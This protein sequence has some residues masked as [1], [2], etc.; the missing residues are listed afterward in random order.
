MTLT[1]MRAL[2][3]LLS[4]LGLLTFVNNWTQFGFL[5]DLGI[6]DRAVA[7]LRTG[8]NPYRADAGLPFIYHPWVL[9]AFEHWDRYLPLSPSLLV[10]YLLAF[11]FAV[12]QSVQWCRAQPASI[13][14]VSPAMLPWADRLLPILAASALGGNGV[15]SVMSGN[16]TSALH[17]I[18]GG[19]ILLAA[20]ARAPRHHLAAT[21]TCLLCAFVKPYF[22]AYLL[23]ILLLNPNPWQWAMITIS[24]MCLGAF[25]ALSMSMEPAQYSLFVQAVARQTLQNN[26]LGY[27]FLNFAWAATH[28]EKLAIGA[29]L[30]LSSLLTLW[31]CMTFA[32][33]QQ[34]ALS[35]WMVP[36]LYLVLT[37]ANPRMKHY[38]LFPALLML[39]ICWQD[40]AMS[41][42]EKAVL[43]ALPLSMMPTFMKWTHLSAPAALGKYALWQALALMLC[44]TCIGLSHR[45]AR[46]TPQFKA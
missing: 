7:D 22:L 43:W 1:P 40:V 46:H 28:N 27:S 3:A 42:F 12:W 44:M 25:W 6:Y 10:F 39:F 45:Q 13:A 26:D 23:L 33:R 4:F 32:R 24:T 2:I 35:R 30:L 29:H 9:E 19:M 14:S 15:V 5:W 41:G 16:I 36:M 31:A 34:G 18:N 38:D 21:L 37:I 17:L 8:V 11:M 20:H